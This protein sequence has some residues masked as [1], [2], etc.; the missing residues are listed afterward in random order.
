[1][2]K[3]IRN[4]ANYLP[5]R[6]EIIIPAAG[7]GSRMK[8]F[9]VKSLIE[10]RPGLPLIKYQTKLINKYLK[11][12]S[13][14]ILVTGFESKKLAN[15][16][17]QSWI[18]VENP[19]YL[20]TNVAKSIGIGLRASTAESIVIIYGDLVFNKYALNIPIRSESVIIVDSHNT[21]AKDEIGCTIINNKVEH[22]W[23]GL[24]H[25]WAQIIYLTGVE[26]K[27]FKELCWNDKYSNNFGFE[28]INEVINMGGI[29]RAIQPYKLKAVDIDHPK[30]L[31]KI[32]TLFQ[33]EL[34]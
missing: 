28:I 24:D 8:T 22:M 9:G 33:S 29:F 7:L 26:L 30:D 20:T 17:P 31:V 12:Y 16:T 14:I 3:A 6:Y 10:L 2:H 18:H 11:N 27:L 32:R 34:Q 4:T 25:K 19:N 23:Y 1:M 21:M 13:Q 5:P 15:S